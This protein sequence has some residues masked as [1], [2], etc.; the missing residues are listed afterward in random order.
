MS[1]KKVHQGYRRDSSNADVASSNQVLPSNLSLDIKS[2]WSAKDEELKNRNVRDDEKM[3]HEVDLE[4]RLG[5]DRSFIIA[6]I[7]G[8]SSSSRIGNITLAQPY[9]L[10]V[11]GLL[12][13]LLIVWSWLP[14]IE[15][16]VL[17]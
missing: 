4:L 12:A 3:E 16:L 2:W 7:F 17:N 13:E 5:H 14:I 15:T 11:G 6:T 9:G 10:I 1:I 8:G